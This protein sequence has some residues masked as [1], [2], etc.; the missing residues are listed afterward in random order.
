[1]L[2][3]GHHTSI[4]GN[5]GIV[6]RT[7]GDFDGAEQ[8]HRKALE[9]DEKLG[10]LEGMASDYGNLGNAL[11]TRGDLD[12][13]EQMYRKSLELAERLGS[14]PLISQ[15]K[16]DLHALGHTPSGLENDE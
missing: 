16:S 12:G 5:L 13:A 6:L 2:F 3:N 11:R 7:R 1:M 10:R 9:I 15:I 14:P 8:M 4:Y